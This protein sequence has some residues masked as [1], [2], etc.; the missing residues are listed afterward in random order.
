MSAPLPDVGL[1]PHILPPHFNSYPS[2]VVENC[3]PLKCI[4]ALLMRI[5]GT[6]SITHNI[7]SKLHPRHNNK[8]THSTL[9]DNTHRLVHFKIH[10]IS[11]KMY[12]I[13]YANSLSRSIKKGMFI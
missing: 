3:D 12:V 11:F 2:T 5:D 4:T 13:I 7:L 1:T 8:Q 10:N 6:D 9:T